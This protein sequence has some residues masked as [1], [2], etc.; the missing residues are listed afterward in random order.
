LRVSEAVI[1]HEPDKRMTART[2]AYMLQTRTVKPADVFDVRAQVEPVA[3]G[4]LRTP[5]AP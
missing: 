5:A 1:V 3:A 4:P 2:A